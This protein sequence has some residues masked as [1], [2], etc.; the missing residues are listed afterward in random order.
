MDLNISKILQGGILVALLAIGGLLYSIRN[1]LTANSAQPQTAPTA[2]APVPAG[3]PA[4]AVPGTAAQP[5]ATPAAAPPAATPAP[6]P[7][8]PPAAA[9]PAPAS[10]E[11]ATRTYTSIPRRPSR[12]EAAEPAP[13]AAAS[14][15]PAPAY[16]PAPEPVPP[17]APAPPPPPIRTV[18]IPASTAIT[19]RLLDAISSERNRAGDT[20][21]A[22]LEQP[23]VVDGMVV[24]DRGASAVGRVVQAQQSGRVAGVAEMA[25]E[26]DRLQTVGGEVQIASDTMMRRAETTH[27]KDAMTTGGLAGLG[28]AIGAIAGGRRG[29]G[30]GAA[31]GG[32]TGAGTV[33]ATKGK[34]VKFDPETQLTFRLRA[35]VTVTVDDAR[36]RSA[37]Y[38]GDS[39][40]TGRPRLSRRN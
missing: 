25:L 18:T 9:A 19:V 15:A 14:P 26:L 27:G 21:Q 33:M 16:I 39:G 3:Q 20:F 28:A 40:S 36:V 23:L 29:A 4:A 5:A 7:A 24:A 30:I 12:P 13:V 34:P 2:G 17:P 32:A 1:H 31:A 6:A 10:R 38:S 8:A 11:R 37:D 22:T 35:P